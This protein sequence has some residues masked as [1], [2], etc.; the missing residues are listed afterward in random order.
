MPN[1]SG[2]TIEIRLSQDG[3]ERALTR[4]AQRDSATVPVGPLLLAFKNGELR[5]ALCPGSGIAIA[6]PFVPTERLVALLR[7]HATASRRR[8]SWLDGKSAIRSLRSRDRRHLG[9]A[10][11]AP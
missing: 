11:P 1:H 7:V 4:L 9:I 8:R 10:S 5:A 6:D 3:D 2:E